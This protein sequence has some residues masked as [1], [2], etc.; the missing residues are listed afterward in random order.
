M[1]LK[2]CINQFH[3][4]QM[5]IFLSLPVAKDNLVLLMELRPN[6]NSVAEYQSRGTI[7]RASSSAAPAVKIRSRNY[8]RHGGDLYRR[9]AKGWLFVPGDKSR[10]SIMIGLDDEIGHFSF[11]T[12]YRIIS[13]RCRP[14]CTKLQLWPEGEFIGIESTA[15]EDASVQIVS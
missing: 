13:D 3:G 15:W 2:F 9:K 5:P 6:S 14:T 11:A 1:T 12:T 8:H 10:A 7:D 4:T